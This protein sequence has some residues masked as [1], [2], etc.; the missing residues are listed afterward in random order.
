MSDTGPWQVGGHSLPTALVDS[1]RAGTW[2]RPRDITGLTAILRDEEEARLGDFYGLAQ[3]RSEMEGLWA[4]AL[5]QPEAAVP[6]GLSTAKDAR[7]RGLLDVGA[8]VPI[9][10]SRSGFFVCLY[11]SP[12]A[13]VP[14]VL[15][16]IESSATGFVWR[17]VAPSFEAFIRAAG[18]ETG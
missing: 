8:A 3:M 13:P 9:L 5:H 4:V 10:G 14:S 16:P 12:G 1:L 17:E 6:L 11:Y 2:R 7:E 15:A 18:I